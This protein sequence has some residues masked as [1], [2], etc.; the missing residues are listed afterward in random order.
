ML[1]KK[2]AE[3]LPR[4]HTRIPKV[5]EFIENFE[6]NLYFGLKWE[7]R[8]FTMSSSLSE[9]VCHLEK[10]NIKVDV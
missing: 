1:L 2:R 7:K 9:I 4:I 8:I 6:Y 3:K 5:V 10:G